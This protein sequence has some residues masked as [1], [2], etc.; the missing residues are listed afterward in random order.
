MITDATIKRRIAATMEQERPTGLALGKALM[1]AFVY[2]IRHRRDEIPKERI[3]TTSDIYPKFEK[4]TKKQAATYEMYEDIQVG[5]TE[6][7]NSADQFDQG[8]YHGYYRFIGPMQSMLATEALQQE[9]GKHA[10]E[11]LNNRVMRLFSNTDYYIN[12]QSATQDIELALQMCKLNLATLYAIIAY[13]EVMADAF[14]IPY[15]KETVMEDIGIDGIEKCVKTL[16]DL[17]SFCYDGLSGTAEESKRKTDFIKQHFPQIDINE[18]KPL[19]QDK[20]RLRDI[21]IGVANPY[22]IGAFTLFQ[23]LLY[24]LNSRNLF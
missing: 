6:A 10:P 20:A 22:S 7:I 4:L 2:D 19:D 13:Y 21:V 18:L 17:L 15:I 9:L 1:L 11:M 16:N 8:F 3:L 12:N 14:N 23:Q 5:F 24:V